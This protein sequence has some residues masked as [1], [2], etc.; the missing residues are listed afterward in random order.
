MH[1]YARRQSLIQS[2]KVLQALQIK[3]HLESQA[4]SQIEEVLKERETNGDD[5]GLATSPTSDAEVMGNS[6]SQP[7]QKSAKAPASYRLDKRQ[8][9]QR[10]EEDRER[11]KRERESIWA[12]SKGEDAEMNKLWEETS[13]F[14]EDDDRLLTEEEEE[15]QKE[16][17]LQLCPHKRETNG[18]SH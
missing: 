9:E 6:A 3:G 11:H 10:L 2:T 5:L 8:I 15:F 7:A 14:G 13:D 1:Y 18:D 4:V 16:M 12:V 17:M